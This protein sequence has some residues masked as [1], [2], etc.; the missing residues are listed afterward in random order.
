M[1]SSIESL[2]S[3]LS[4]QYSDIK[5]LR[6]NFPNSSKHF[7]NDNELKLMTQ[8]GVYPYDFIDTYDKLNID[9]LPNQDD[10]YSKLYNSKCSDEDYKQAKLVWHTFK[11]KTFMDYHNLYLKSDV[12]L[13]AD[14]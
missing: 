11:C 12:L 13:L 8:K 2:V 9:Y 5:Q 10:F 7:K 14:V 3:N 4:K 1:A 6:N